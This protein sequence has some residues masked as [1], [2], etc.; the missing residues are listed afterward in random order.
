[1]IKFDENPAA[2]A[3]ISG[4]VKYPGLNGRVEFYDTFGGTVVAVYTN[5]FYPEEVIGRT[6]IIHGGV[7]DFHTQP[8]GN[9]GEMIACGQI[10][11]WKKADNEMVKE[12]Q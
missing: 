1:M 10:V 11:P 2:F 9:S 4:S 12:N 5:R 6:V 8:S 3:L 7:D